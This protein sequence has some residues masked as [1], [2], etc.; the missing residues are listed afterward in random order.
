MASIRNGKIDYILKQLCR[1]N[2]KSK[3]ELNEPLIRDMLSVWI[4]NEG[5]FIKQK[6]GVL[7]ALLNIASAA[8]D[9]NRGF[10]LIIQELTIDNVNDFSP[11]TFYYLSYILM[12]YDELDFGLANDFMRYAN[13]KK[14]EL[15][16]S[17]K[18]SLERHKF[19]FFRANYKGEVFF[20]VIFILGFSKYFN[21]EYRNSFNSNIEN[22]KF[23][24][25]FL[26]VFI[27]KYTDQQLRKTNFKYITQLLPNPLLDIYLK[28]LNSINQAS[29]NLEEK[30]DLIFF[31]HE[32]NTLI[33]TKE[34]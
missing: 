13:L 28:K 23:A 8:N 3:I 34:L 17:Y 20:Y 9:L 31:L 27:E 33:K 5:E 26:T 15:E 22:E 19:R 29:L 21:E 11:A 7:E 25:Q 1:V 10:N 24:I 2:K 6:E 16:K 18:I 12:F 32:I 4:N 14:I 30:N